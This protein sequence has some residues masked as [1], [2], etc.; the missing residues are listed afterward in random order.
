V[1][2]AWH[3]SPASRGGVPEVRCYPAIDIRDGRCVRLLR[4]DFASETV[5][6]DPL[7]VA[8]SYLAG[9]AEWLHV[10]D[11]DAARRGD[12]VNRPLVLAIAA[13]SGVKV[14][15][16][17]GVRDEAAVEVLLEGGV[18][19]VVLGTLAASSP[20]LAISL[21]ERHPGRVAVAIDHAAGGAVVVEGWG[22]DSGLAVADLLSRLGDAPF[23]AVVVTSVA[24]DG[25][26]AGPDLEG[27]AATLAATTLPVVASG[28][29]GG[30]DDLR[31]LAALRAGGRSL[32][33]AIVGRALLSGALDLREAIAACAT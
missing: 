30:A 11:L 1:P 5:F 33:G 23:G 25:T 17:G 2:P 4:G 22:V 12:P 14:Q 6:G 15:A 31:A 19:R 8:R 24:R 26:L 10:V 21:A 28:G 29:V 13:L 9:G 16:G 32:D 7:E 3:C 18:E 20:E 27:L